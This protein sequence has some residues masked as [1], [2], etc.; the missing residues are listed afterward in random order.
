MWYFQ[1]FIRKMANIYKGWHLYMLQGKY[2]INY[3]NI[4]IFINIVFILKKKIFLRCPPTSSKRRIRSEYTKPKKPTWKNTPE[5]A[6]HDWWIQ[7]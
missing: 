4:Y 5:T 2:E 1:I 3:N 7:N 6:I